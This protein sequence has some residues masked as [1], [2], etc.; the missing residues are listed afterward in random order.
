RCLPGC[1]VACPEPCAYSRSLGPCVA[2][3]GDSTALVYGPPVMVTFPGA[4][5][6]SCPQESVVASSM[7]QHSGGS[8]YSLGMGG[9]SGGL[10]GMG[11]SYGS[12]G[13]YS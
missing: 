4:I 7:P 12:G 5:L 6:S 1:E 9:S 3:C 13:S 11:G 8:S 2:S 10:S